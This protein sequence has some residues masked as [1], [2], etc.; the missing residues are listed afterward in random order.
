[1]R[2]AAALRARVETVVVRRR[3]LH[4]GQTVQPLSVDYYDSETVQNI[5]G[6]S[7]DIYGIVATFSSEAI[8][9]IAAEDDLEVLIIPA[10]DQRAGPEIQG[11]EFRCDLDDMRLKRGYGMLAP[12]LS[13]MWPWLVGPAMLALFL[14]LGGGRRLRGTAAG[15]R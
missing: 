7:V 8:R 1:M 6:A 9:E 5:F 11:D 3:G 12:R 4:G 13:T 15:R 10:R 14:F 2:T